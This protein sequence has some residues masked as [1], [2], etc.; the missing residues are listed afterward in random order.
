MKSAMNSLPF[1]TTSSNKSLRSFHFS[2][3]FCLMLTN[4]FSSIALMTSSATLLSPGEEKEE[5]EW[6][7]SMFISS[8]F[9]SDDSNSRV[10][11]EKTNLVPREGSRVERSEVVDT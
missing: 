10:E 9:R 6:M 5:E 3:K 8:S 4:P 7:A 11:N 2:Q 1:A